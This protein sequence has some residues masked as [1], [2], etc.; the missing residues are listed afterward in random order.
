MEIDAES[1]MLRKGEIIGKLGR[2]YIWRGMREKWA[3]P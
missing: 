1:I 3:E 2:I